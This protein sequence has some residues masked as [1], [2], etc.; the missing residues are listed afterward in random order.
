MTGDRT[1]QCRPVTS[2][3]QSTRRYPVTDERNRKMFSFEK[4]AYVWAEV[5][6]KDAL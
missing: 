6:Q 2:P 4:E 3:D 1:G 5:E